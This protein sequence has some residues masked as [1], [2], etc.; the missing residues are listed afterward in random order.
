MNM[1]ADISNV[2]IDWTAIIIL[3]FLFLY[4]IIARICELFKD[5]VP[6]LNEDK[7]SK[8]TVFRFLQEDA[9]GERTISLIYS[10]KEYTYHDQDTFW[11]ED[12]DYEEIEEKTETIKQ[13]LLQKYYTW[14]NEV[15]L[16]EVPEE[17]IELEED[18]VPEKD[19]E[20]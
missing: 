10:T 2:G 12:L 6:D 14:L 4:L 15:R 3:G 20:E 18:E 17:D 11:K 5:E 19:L 1:F 9:W 8:K 13:Q 7:S 16:V